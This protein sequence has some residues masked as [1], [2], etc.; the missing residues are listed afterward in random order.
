[1]SQFVVGVSGGI[2]S[3]KTTVTDLFAEK[4]I[5]VIDADVIAR[6]VV[7]PGTQALELIIE[8]FGS[9]ILT[10]E[11]SLD[12]KALRQLI[13]AHPEQ[14]NW[15]NAL[16]H[17]LIRQQMIEQTKGATSAYCL[18]S[19]PLLVENNLTSLVNRVLIVDVDEHTQ[20][21][22]SVLRDKSNEQ[23]IRSIMQAQATREERLKVADDVINNN[24]GIQQLIPQINR[25]HQ[26]YLTL[27]K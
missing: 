20:I 9:T 1:M 5:A 11:N 7:E 12:R 19:V 26:E 10:T 25:L 13:F 23:Q 14:K 4:N 8:K 18:L 24:H 22:R 21:Q 3:G 6:E 27:A 17:P 2:G 16:L 15:L